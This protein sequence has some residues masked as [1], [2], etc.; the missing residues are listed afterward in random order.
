[1]L[2][3]HFRYDPVHKR[4]PT[5][6]DHTA[7]Q[8]AIASKMRTNRHAQVDVDQFR[9]PCKIPPHRELGELGARR[10]EPA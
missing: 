8:A 4:L 3:E 6:R 9:D 5:E 10:Q 2:A 1:M 7:H